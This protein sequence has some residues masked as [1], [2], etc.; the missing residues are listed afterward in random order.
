MRPFERLE[1]LP[2]PE[3]P[4]VRASA[5]V[6]VDVSTVELTLTPSFQMVLVAPDRRIAMTQVEASVKVLT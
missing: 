1:V 3:P 6:V 5:P 2:T 4:T